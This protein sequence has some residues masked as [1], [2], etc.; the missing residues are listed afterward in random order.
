MRGALF[1]LRLELCEFRKSKGLRLISSVEKRVLSQLH[2]GDDAAPA[3]RI[4][5]TATSQNRFLP[6]I[7]WS[8]TFRNHDM[9]KN[10]LKAKMARG[11]A[12]TNGWLALGSAY[13]AELMGHA[14]FDS[15]T[16]DCQH[17][18][19]DFT[20]MLPMLQALSSTPATPIVR[21]P[22]ND[23]AKI[24]HALDAGAYGIICPMINNVSEAQQLVRSCRYEPE[25]ARSYGPAR[26]LLY[27]GADYFAH[28]NREIVALA[29][30][31]TRDGVANAEEILAVPGIDGIYIGP[32]DLALALGAKPGS[33]M[34]DSRVVETIA[35]LLQL[36]RA[37]GKFAGIFCGSA[38]AAAARRGQGF[39][40]VTLPHEA[41]L[42]TQAAKAAI[43]TA[44][45][46]ETAATS[47]VAHTQNTY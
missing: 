46:G 10:E 3:H 19:F 35:R 5:N 29:M 25:G 26:G 17:G 8:D 27:G 23:S 32:N 42:L 6:Y 43:A 38:Q 30:I 37:A 21:V 28:A 4:S 22:W 41:S 31:E 9:R 34:T 15:V 24:M 7:Q 47:K 20:Q 40:L 14:G 11:D 2:R 44:L 12:T 1:F 45:G 18:M 13:S 39:H 16:V 33:D 36:A